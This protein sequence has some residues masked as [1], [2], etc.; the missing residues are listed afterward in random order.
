MVDSSR[1]YNNPRVNLLVVV[2][3]GELSADEAENR[4]SLLQPTETMQL[5]RDPQ[6]GTYRAPLD[7]QPPSTVVVMAVATITGQ[8]EGAV[9]PLGTVVDP[10]ALDALFAPR[11]DGTARRGGR[12]SFRF[13][14]FDVTVAGGE[15][16]LAP[17]LT[18]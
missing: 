15:V 18:D 4:A 2:N 17:L 11:L 14:D 16:R 7:G 3:G 13:A 5:E 8:E 10:D 6:T 12:V 1:S 9:E